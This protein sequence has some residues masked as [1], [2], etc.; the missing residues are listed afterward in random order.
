MP[1]GICGVVG[2]TDYA[3]KRAIHLSGVHKKV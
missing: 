3:G 1:A 2:G